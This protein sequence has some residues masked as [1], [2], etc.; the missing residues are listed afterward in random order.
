M[1]SNTNELLPEPETPVKTVSRRFGISMLTSLR[2]F[3]RA[4][5]TRIRSWLS[6]ACCAPVLVALLMGTCPPVS[7]ASS[8]M[9]THTPSARLLDADHVARG[10]EE[11]TV[12]NAVRLLDRLLDPL[13]AGPEPLGDGGQV[14]G[15]EGGGGGE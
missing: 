10:V 14:G 5:C 13:R 3:S 8:T 11:G 7:T 4:P 1:V 2:L 12:P 15:G 9:S 6:A